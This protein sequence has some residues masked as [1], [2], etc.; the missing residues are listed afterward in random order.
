ME[1]SYRM[2]VRD[3]APGDEEQFDVPIPAFSLHTPT[4][5]H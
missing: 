1:G 4:A 3:G 5:V 2:V